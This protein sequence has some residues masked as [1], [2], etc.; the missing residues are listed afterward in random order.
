VR[1]LHVYVLVYVALVVGA[2]FTLWRAGMLDRV[3]PLITMM[4]IVGAL[5]LAG[6]LLA[7]AKR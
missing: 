7:L 5:A 2:A 6:V 1:G 3:T 4:A